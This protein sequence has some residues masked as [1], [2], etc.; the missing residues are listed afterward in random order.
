MS[1]IRNRI[2]RLLGIAI[3][4]GA[5]VGLMLFLERFNI[6]SDTIVWKSLRNFGHLPL[7]GLM[8]VILLWFL[9][10]SVGKRVDIPI[11]YV[12]AWMG[13]VG[14]GALSE[15]LQLPTRRD[16]NIID[17]LI[18]IAGATSFLALH[19]TIDPWISSRSNRLLKRHRIIIRIVAVLII[20]AAAI[21]LFV[22]CW[23]QL[24]RKT[25]FPALYTFDSYFE[26]KY[27][28]TANADLRIVASPSGWSGS[29]SRVA[30]IDFYPSKYPTVYFLGPYPDWTGHRVLSIDV[31]S[32]ADN[33]ITIYVTI[34]DRR[35]ASYDDRYNT[36]IQVQ[37]G[38]N[39]VEI[40]LSDIENAPE[41]RKLD[42]SSITD[43]YIF[44]S[45][46]EHTIILYM[47]NMYLE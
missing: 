16:A 8:A 2:A 33:P 27:L 6:Q 14:I 20:S 39:R 45:D 22:S 7:F 34:K 19:F 30:E 31:F 43:V 29:E 36:Q 47:D 9:R 35:D 44:M 42:L 46:P 5:A 18:D 23:A 1:I 28:D 41:N 4:L 37:S 12:I 13:T 24:Y 21:P 32:P 11:Q 38:Y 10:L 3:L 40:P 25:I 15:Y 17:W 26:R